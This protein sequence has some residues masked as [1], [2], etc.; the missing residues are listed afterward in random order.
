MKRKNPTPQPHKYID[1]PAGC[2]GWQWGTLLFTTNA[3]NKI[4]QSNDWIR[5]RDLLPLGYAYEGEFII[6][7]YGHRDL[8]LLT[9]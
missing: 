1:W 4:T 8:F 9:A 3:E 5:I 7:A 6:D 2:A